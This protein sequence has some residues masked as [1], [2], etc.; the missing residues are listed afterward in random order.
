MEINLPHQAAIDDGMKNGRLRSITRKGH[1]S[2]HG[3]FRSLGANP[4]E[5]RTSSDI[6][7]LDGLILSGGEST[8]RGRLLRDPL[9]KLIREGLPVLAACA[10]LILL[11]EHMSNDDRAY[12]AS[13]PVTVRRNAYG[14]QLGS[15]Q[16]TDSYDGL[17][18]VE[19]TFFRAPYIEKVSDDSEVLASVDG[20]IVVVSYKNQTAMAFHPELGKNIRIHK[21]FLASI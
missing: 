8:V 11:A 1:L 4:I 15:F 13:L 7:N 17:G 21:Q 18:D 2:G 10:G 6:E 3:D 16:T 19:M 20:H 12:F 14:R 5:L 9:K